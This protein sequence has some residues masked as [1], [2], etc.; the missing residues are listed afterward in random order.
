[1]FISKNSRVKGSNPE[2]Q[3]IQLQHN[4]VW[5]PPQANPVP[6]PLGAAPPN[7][8]PHIP[9]PLP[10]PPMA[11]FH[12][13]REDWGGGGFGML[14][15]LPPPPR[16]PPDIVQQPVFHGAQNPNIQDVQRLNLRSGQL[17]GGG[18]RGGLQGP[19]APSPQSLNLSPRLNPQGASQNMDAGSLRLGAQSGQ[20]NRAEGAGS[21]HAG[22][23]ETPGPS[24]AQDSQGAGPELE[25]NS[26]SPRSTSSNFP[27]VDGSSSSGSDAN[28]D[29][30]GAGAQALRP[31]FPSIRPNAMHNRQRQL[32]MLRKHEDRLRSRNSNNSHNRANNN[33]S[34][35]RGVDCL[36]R[37]PMVIHI[38]DF[39]EAVATGAATWLPTK[40]T[41][42]PGA[43]EETIFYSLVE[44]R[45]ELVMFGGIQRDQNPM[46]RVNSPPDSSSHIVS[47]SLCIISPNWQRRA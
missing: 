41:P 42:L 39:R 14:G 30:E 27:T 40:D 17:R 37:N 47:N 20:L 32:D 45:A 15:V 26:L 8:H 11:A 18:P 9:P 21:S 23:S 2:P 35:A 31:G 38:L 29:M 24:H 19:Q 1:M 6:P 7:N 10:F 5:V 46:Q 25:A 12:R 3:H 4:R 13:R 43:P 34:S 16:G 44:G 33:S 28:P 22:S 36:P